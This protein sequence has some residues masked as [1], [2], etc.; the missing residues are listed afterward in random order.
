VIPRRRERYE[1]PALPRNF[2]AGAVAVVILAA[3]VGAALVLLASTVFI[4]AV[5]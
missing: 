4:Q 3:A 5:R 2:D 1:R